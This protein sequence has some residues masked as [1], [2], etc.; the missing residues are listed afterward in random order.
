MMSCVTLGNLVDVSEC[1]FS[2]LQNGVKTVFAF[3]NI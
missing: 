1:L 3:Q 2:Q